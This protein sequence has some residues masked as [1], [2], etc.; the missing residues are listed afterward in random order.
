MLR[1]KSLKQRNRANPLVQNGADQTIEAEHCL[2]PSFS[3]LRA[4][5]QLSTFL[6][7]CLSCTHIL[8]FVNTLPRQVRSG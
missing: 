5:T 7:P 1:I 3:V 2:F 4:A 8:L 6:T